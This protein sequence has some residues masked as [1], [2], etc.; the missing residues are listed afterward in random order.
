MSEGSHLKT[1][2]ALR[3]ILQETVS[4]RILLQTIQNGEHVPFGK[5][6]E[7]KLTISKMRN[8]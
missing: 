7:E 3:K 2:R 4:T 5:Q 1:H 8:E 6:K